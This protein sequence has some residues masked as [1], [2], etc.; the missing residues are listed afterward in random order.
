MYHAARLT[1]IFQE[2]SIPLIIGVLAGLATAN[3][4]HSFYEKL[5]D[6][7]LFGE[8]AEVFGHAL[9][10]HFLINEVFMVLFFGIAAKE[11]TDSVLPGGALNPPN[12][13]INPLMATFGGILGPVGMYFLLTTLIYGGTENFSE[14]ANG[15]GIPTATDIALAWLVARVVFGSHH[16][17]VNF[18]LL[19]AVADDA[20]GLGIIAVFYPD[21]HNPVEPVWL[22][23][24]L[25]GI[26]A[27]YGLRRMHFGLWPIYVLIG[28]GLSWSGLAL[29]GVEPALALVVIVPFLPGPRLDP[30][31]M[32]SHA[33]QH[34]ELQPAAAADHHQGHAISPL[35]QFE[36]QLKLFVDLG[37]F[38][39]AFANAGVA[40]GSIN[41]VTLI[42]LL[43]LVVG[44]TV[45]VS[46]FSWTATYLG[47]PLPP[48]MRFKHL[49]V[50]G[51][52]SGLGLTVALFVA[53][54][55]FPA[56]SM[57][58]D[59]AKMGAVLS[60]GVAFLAIGIG[61]ALKL[62]NTSEQDE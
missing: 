48:D 40:F 42:I 56:E 51:L 57:F 44:K 6:F 37:L 28:G 46:L 10:V 24:T 2:F 58:Q 8:H 4:D 33:E 14:V 12:K 18:L 25:S 29:S 50:T 21:P 27:A 45:G 53:G 20:I 43:S 11:I 60:A 22:L 59:P 54:K 38:F 35:D 5:V 26:A 30:V 13:A 7:H 9:T 62:R 23:L 36:H 19:L 39:F 52:I 49:A 55:A 41:S 31:L 47:F 15:W 16:S 34:P 1:N 32:R 61:R 17:A 3:I